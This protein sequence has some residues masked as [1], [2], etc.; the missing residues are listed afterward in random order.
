MAV[1]AAGVAKSGYPTLG[2]RTEQG[3]ILEEE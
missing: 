3:R 1:A 2:G